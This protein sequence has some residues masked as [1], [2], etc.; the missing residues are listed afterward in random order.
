MEL[1]GHS[2][3]RQVVHSTRYYQPSLRSWHPEQVANFRRQNRLFPDQVFCGLIL[4]SARLIFDVPICQNFVA[5]PMRLESC[6][7]LQLIL[8]SQAIVGDFIYQGRYIRTNVHSYA[9]HREFNVGRRSQR[10][11][12]YIQGVPVIWQDWKVH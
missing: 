1:R 2:E 8:S 9:T 3:V 5:C 6:W 11:N 7:D 12:I 10:Y 4:L